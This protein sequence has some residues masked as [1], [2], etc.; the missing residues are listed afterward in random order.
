LICLKG[1]P[2]GR[3][4]VPRM[5]TQVDMALLPIGVAWLAVLGMLAGGA[6]IG[7][8]R[9]LKALAGTATRAPLDDSPLPFFAMLQSR[10]LTVEQLESAVGIQALAL[11]VRRCV[12]CSLRR[13]CAGNAAGC[14]NDGLFSRVQV[15]REA[16]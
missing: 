16:R 11:A 9:V 6:A 8:W 14:P 7:L 4:S 13:A 2:P 5:E 15:L 1:F 12:F 10:G 3:R